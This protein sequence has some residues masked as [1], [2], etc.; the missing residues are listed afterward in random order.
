MAAQVSQRVFLHLVTEKFDGCPGM[1]IAGQVT[2]PG[3]PMAAQVS[4]HTTLPSIPVA[5]QVIP[6]AVQVVRL[7]SLLK[8]HVWRRRH[9]YLFLLWEFG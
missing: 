8:I 5:A 2:L 6:V 7:R 9:R 4:Q 3:I 1:P